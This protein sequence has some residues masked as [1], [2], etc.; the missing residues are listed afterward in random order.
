LTRYDVAVVGSG[1]G[2]S[3]AALV[4][5]RGGAR[6][7]LVDKAAFPRDKACGDIVGPRGLQVL[8]DL[9]VKMP[10]GRDVGDI[11]VVG[12]TGRRVRLPCGEGLTYPGHGTAVARRDLDNLL[13]DKAVEEGATP[14]RDRVEDPLWN[15]GRLDGYRLG[16][17]KE[18]RAD[19]V[20]GADGATSR[21]ARSTGLTDDRRVLWGFAVRTYLSCDVELPAIVFWE[22]SPWRGFPGYGWVFPGADGGANVGLGVATLSDRTLGATAARLFPKFLEHVAALGLVR[23]PSP[24]TT[25][26]QLGGWLKM[27][28]VG[29][30]PAAGRAFLVGDAAGLVNPL[31]GEGI[32]QAVGSGRLAAEAILGET[33]DAAGWYRARLAAEHLPYH[34]VAAAIQRASVGRPRAVAAT[35]RFLVTI[36]RIDRLAGGWSVF[37]NELLEGAPR[38]QHRAIARGITWVGRVSTAHTSTARWF[39]GTLPVARGRRPSGPI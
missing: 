1:P 39:E 15:E 3:V 18:L 13:H 11:L 6:V 7:A 26:R 12:P 9:G 17:G 25:G 22:P 8:R 2:G 36:G 10:A 28:I 4:L 33:G 35:A 21:V 14:I 19:F 32:A 30:N 29:T 20:I 38:N 27:G 24:S 34:R 5:A 23:A 16:G 37:W 31:Q